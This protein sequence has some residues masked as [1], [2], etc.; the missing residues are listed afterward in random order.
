ML[1]RQVVRRVGRALRSGMA[2]LESRFKD[3]TRPAKTNQVTATLAD[4]TRCKGELMAENVFLRQ[5]LIVLER[6]VA[7]PQLRQRDR[8][9]LVVQECQELCGNG[10]PHQIGN[11]SSKRIANWLRMIAQL[12]IGIVHFLTISR[13]AS[14]SNLRAA[15][16]DGNAA[17]WTNRIRILLPNHVDRWNRIMPIGCGPSNP[18]QPG[19]IVI[20]SH[21]CTIQPSQPL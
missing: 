14:H 9:V 15:S 3:W 2:A 12:G 8:Q 1:M 13:W 5:Q 7:R 19:V 20:F 6:Q 21:G 17:R 16:G 11:R 4:L 18:A 10:V